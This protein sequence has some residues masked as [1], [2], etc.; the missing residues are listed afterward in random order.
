MFDL[1]F[2]RFMAFMRFRSERS[3][4]AAVIPGSFLPVKQSKIIF[5]YISVYKH[6]LSL[7]MSIQY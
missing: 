3:R 7:E 5:I 6:R 2:F 1:D 4:S